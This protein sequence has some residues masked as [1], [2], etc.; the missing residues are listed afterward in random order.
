MIIAG[1]R[2]RVFPASSD[3]TPGKMIFGAQP[4]ADHK[5]EVQQIRGF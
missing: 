4:T 3:F 1:F 5:F 2:S